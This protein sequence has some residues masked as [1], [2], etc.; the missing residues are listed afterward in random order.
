LKLSLTL[1]QV[2]NCVFQSVEMELPQP[3]RDLR[4]EIQGYL[5]SDRWGV[6]CNFRKKLNCESKI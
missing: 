6:Q 1:D 2:F 3:P 4:G 5:I